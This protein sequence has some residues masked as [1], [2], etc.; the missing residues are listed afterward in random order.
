[1]KNQIHRFQ[2][3]SLTCQSHDKNIWCGLSRLNFTN[4]WNTYGWTDMKN[5]EILQLKFVSEKNDIHCIT[6]WQQLEK[7]HS[8]QEKN[9]RINHLFNAKMTHG[10]LTRTS[11]VWRVIDGTVWHCHSTEKCLMKE[12]WVDDSVKKAWNLD[13]RDL[14][15][16]PVSC[17]Q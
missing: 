4:A 12:V 3:E 9:D 16:F 6:D 17:Q 2:A 15:L 7:R 5:F 8:S 11:C 13:V 14:C 1:M 10:F